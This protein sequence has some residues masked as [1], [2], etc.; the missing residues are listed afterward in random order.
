M[1]GALLAAHPGATK[2]SDSVR[3]PRLRN[4]RSYVPP[5]A[6]IHAL[7]CSPLRYAEF[8]LAAF[9]GPCCVEAAAV[10]LGRGETG[11]GACFGGEACTSTLASQFW[12]IASQ[13][14]S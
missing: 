1:V 10:G 9:F 14:S 6:C 3:P 2:T 4:P 12:A 5:L 13:F 8:C 11:V 7:I